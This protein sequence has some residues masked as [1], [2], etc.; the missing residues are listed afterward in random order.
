VAEP[1]YD[2]DY[3]PR[4][5]LPNVDD[6]P[7]T[8]TGVILMSLDADRLLAGLGAAGPADDPAAVALAVDRARHGAG[9]VSLPTLVS[10][11]VE[12]WLRARTAL[13]ATGWLPPASGSL[14]QSWTQTLAL[15][16][17]VDGLPAGAPA[18]RAYLATCW[19]RRAAVDA[20]ADAAR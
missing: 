5:A 16:D 17:S 10:A 11:G 9:P 3:D 15:L 6:P 13:D 8:E 2:P 1:S 18:A 14:R 7:L 20:V 4:A 12:R 19:I